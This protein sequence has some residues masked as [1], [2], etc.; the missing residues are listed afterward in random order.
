MEK[1]D[2]IILLVGAN[3]DLRDH[4]THNWLTETVGLRNCLHEKHA[5]LSPP[6]TYFRN[7]R[8]KPIGGCYI[9]P[10][11]IIGKGGFLPFREGIGDH[12][13]LYIDIDINSWLEG[14]LHKIVPLQIRRLKCEDV[15]IV[16]NFLQELRKKTR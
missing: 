6:S 16:R 4:I 2:Q 7:F 5:H 9:S 8:H 12:R 11:M 13:I 14:D 10:N 3:D 1:G 15:R